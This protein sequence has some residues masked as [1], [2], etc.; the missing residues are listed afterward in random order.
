MIHL[1]KLHGS[2]T[3]KTGRNDPRRPVETGWREHTAHEC[4]LYFGYKSVP[5][6]EPF[7]TLHNLL[8]TALLHCD[9]AIV[10]GFRFADPYIREIFDFA[11]R[12]NSGL[13]L[14][15]SLTRTP[16]AK[17]PISAMM[18]QFPKRVALL[19]GPSDNPLPFGHTNFQGALARSL[20]TT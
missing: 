16:E 2:I 10:I 4:L 17:S 7:I 6:D 3:W 9:T 8:K 11:L 14:I 13:R 12:A 20:A 19:A 5:E 18:E 15:C 1:V